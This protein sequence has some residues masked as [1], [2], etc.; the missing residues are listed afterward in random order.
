MFTR[1]C[2][3]RT[4]GSCKA[5]LCCLALTIAC[6]GNDDDEERFDNLPDCVV[7]H[8]S[9]GEARS[10]T[11]CLIDFPALHPTLANQQECVDWVAAN[12]GYVD[13][14]EAACTEYFEEAGA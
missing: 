14:R 1:E 5:L 10:I 7:G 3:R 4:R 12:G 9:L 8:A 2:I 6:G 13:S 11:H